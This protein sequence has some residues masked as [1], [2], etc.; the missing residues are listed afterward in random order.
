MNLAAVDLG[1]G[2]CTRTRVCSSL[3]VSLTLQRERE[4]EGEGEKRGASA[5]TEPPHARVA[6]EAQRVRPENSAGA[7]ATASECVR[8]IL[9]V[10]GRNLASASIENR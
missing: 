3:A 9:K 5:T 7:P 2:S 4:E 6:A 1:A 10:C 8:N